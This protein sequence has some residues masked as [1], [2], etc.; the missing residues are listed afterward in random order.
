MKYTVAKVLIS[1]TALFLM[2]S[3]VGPG[4]AALRKGTN[5]VIPNQIMKDQGPTAVIP[6]KDS[7]PSLSDLGVG[8]IFAGFSLGIMLILRRPHPDQ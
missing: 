1:L 5:I 4:R 3:L 7:K 8:S 2:A 6:F